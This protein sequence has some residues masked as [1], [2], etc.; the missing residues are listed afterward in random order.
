MSN[1]WGGAPKSFVVL[2]LSLVLLIS[3]CAKPGK[4]AVSQEIPSPATDDEL[5]LI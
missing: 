3:C 1:E 4:E 2:G 5:K